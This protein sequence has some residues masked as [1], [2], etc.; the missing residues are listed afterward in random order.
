MRY[1]RSLAVLLLAL[2]FQFLVGCSTKPGP[3]PWEDTNRFFHGFNDNLDK[4]LLK[5]VADGYVKIVPKE[6]RTGINNGFN[7]L[8]Y[9]EVIVNDFLQ[10]QWEQGFRDSGRM[11]INTTIGIA[12]IFDFATPMGLPAHD[13]DFGITLGKWGV[14]PGPYLVL[15][16]V[17][18]YT[19]RDTAGIPVRLV[20]SPLFWIQPELCI[21]IP[22]DILKLIDTRADLDRY[23]RFREENALD[24]YIFTR[25]AY[26]KHREHKVRG[27]KPAPDPTLYE[28][29]EPDMAPTTSTAPSTQP[30][31]P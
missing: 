28:D 25:E 24:P 17:G 7:N 3:D 21:S 15:P 31:P 16:L 1:T 4:Y 2:A 23:L 30:T 13:T 27:G 20:T 14:E 8:T 18:P 10:G 29:P 19:V 22:L 6:I 26:L 9:G 11:A 12:G 5:P